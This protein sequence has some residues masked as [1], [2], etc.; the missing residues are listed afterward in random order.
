MYLVGFSLKRVF[1]YI[2]F[3]NIVCNSLDK[4]YVNFDY[5]YLKSVNRS[6]KYLSIKAKLL[7]PVTNLKIRYA[8]LKRENGYKPFLYNIT[9]DGCTFVKSNNNPV[10]KFIFDSFKEYTNIN[11]S[12]PFYDDFTLEKLDTKTL[13]DNLSRLPVPAGQYGSLATC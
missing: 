2:E 6:Y 3:T 12:C 4:D 7:K 9:F 11:H 1:S 5:C 10:T 13:A 8:F